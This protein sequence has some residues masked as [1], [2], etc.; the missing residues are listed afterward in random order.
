M[1]WGEQTKRGAA[2]PT[3]HAARRGQSAAT[4][5]PS[6]G[7]ATTGATPCG[8]ALRRAASGPRMWLTRA[9]HAAPVSAEGTPCARGGSG[10]TQLL[11]A[12]M[13][14]VCGRSGGARL[15][16]VHLAHARHGHAQQRARAAAPPPTPHCTLA[17]MLART[18]RTCVP[19]VHSLS[20]APVEIVQLA[21]TSITYRTFVYES[22]LFWILFLFG[23]FGRARF[24]AT[25]SDSK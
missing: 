11:R 5:Q 20:R 25:N 7:V 8:R 1:G 14:R 23:R 13:V 18:S 21:E 22:L 2:R 15:P 17:D 12:R 16:R 9:H 6:H 10:G 4:R 24:Q 3:A 19:C